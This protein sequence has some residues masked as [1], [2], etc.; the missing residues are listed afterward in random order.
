MLQE[1]DGLQILIAAVHVPRRVSALSPVVQ[2]E[3]GGHR[4][5]PDAVRVIFLRPEE[6]IRD[7]EIADL[8]PRIVEDEGSPVR[9]ASPHRVR[10]LIESPSVKGGEPPAVPRK[11]CGRPVQDDA[12]P[13][14]VKAVDE[15]LEI[16]RTPEAG[17]RRV[18]AGDLVAPG[19]IEGV[20]HHRHELHMGIALGLHIGCD[21]LRKLPVIVKFRAGN[22]TSVLIDRELF[23]KD[24]AQMEL[25]DRHR[26][27]LLSPPLLSFLPGP[28]LPV[29][30]AEI[31]DDGGCIRAEL[32]GKA[33]GICLQKGLLPV[34]ENFVFVDRALGKT[35]EKELKDAVVRYFLHHIAASVP[36]IE[37]PDHGDAERPGGP[38]GENDAGSSA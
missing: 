12:D 23:S 35:G 29:K 18:I 7:Q 3:H 11:M 34:A 14:L 20:F 2:V 8:V 25:V 24:G 30:A 1:F 32:E 21:L 13:L 28:V 37:V 4:V 5:H 9:M 16:L 27:R 22:R 19:L 33:V 10:I 38:D 17:A 6:S 15:V 31:G 36:E 26:L